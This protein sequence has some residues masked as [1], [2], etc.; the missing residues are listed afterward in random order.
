MSGNSPFN[1]PRLSFWSIIS[2][3]VG[4]FGIQYSFGL[5]QTN[6]TPIY[7]YLGA[8]PDQIPLLNLAGPM[9]GLIIQPIIGAMSDKTISKW[10]RRRPYFLIGAI[11]CS[12]CLFFMPFSR[13]LWMAAGL[14]WIL[15][16]GNN[17]TMEPYRAFVSDKLPPQQ[18]ATGF[19]SQSFFT[20]LGITLANL[21]PGLLV[22]LHLIDKNARSSNNITYTTYAAF[23]IGSV[24]SIS[25]I[26]Y[27]ILTTKEYPLSV[28]EIKEIKSSPSGITSIF[29]D[30]AHAFKNMPPTMRQLGVVYFFNWYAMFIYWQFITL[31]VAQTIYHTSDSKSDGFSSAQLLTGTLNGTYNIVTFCVAFLLAAVAKKIGAKRVHMVSLL[32]SGTG[33]LLIPLINNANLLIIPMIGFGIG[34]ASMMGTPYV[35]LAGQIPANKTG[36]YMGILNMFIVFPMLL[37][38]ITFRFIYNGVLGANPVHAIQFAGGLILTAAVL[39][40]TVK[41]SKIEGGDQI[42]IPIGGH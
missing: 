23:L 27:S 19:L 20:G 29:K 22:A 11:I 41:V 35:M 42:L 37:E 4:F 14:L 30:I 3:N 8:N 7:S 21:T 32:L 25:S 40:L 28:E 39:V 15:D 13:S 24:V 26:M 34:W 33:L 18:H 12:L 17:I 2:M 36:I 31:C 5:Q 16:A 1:K 38:T 10:G 6:M 9:T